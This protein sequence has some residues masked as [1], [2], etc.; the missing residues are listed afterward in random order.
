MIPN[1]TPTFIHDD[2][3]GL[4]IADIDGHQ[5]T[6][7][8]QAVDDTTLDFQSTFVPHA[9]REQQIGTR[10]VRY[11]LEWAR[12]RKMKVIPSC[13]FVGSV[14]ERYPEFRDLLTR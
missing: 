8:Y 14:V 3:Q 1:A 2:E 5:A 12:E 10:L 11:G 13:W 6:L 4:F 9:L 7:T